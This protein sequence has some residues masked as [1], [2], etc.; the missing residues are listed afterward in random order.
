MARYCIAFDSMKQFLKIKGK[1]SLSDMVSKC[2]ALLYSC[3][4]SSVL[5][6]L[7]CALLVSIVRRF[8]N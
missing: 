5:L 4:N 1:E 6:L 8:T 3:I 7:C 2:F